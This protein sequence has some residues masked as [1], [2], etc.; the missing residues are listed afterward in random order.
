MT[1]RVMTRSATAKAQGRHL[2]GNRTAGGQANNGKRKKAERNRTVKQKSARSTTKSKPHAPKKT[3]SATRSSNKPTEAASLDTSTSPEG[4]GDADATH[5][6]DATME[7]EKSYKA[8]KKELK[9][10][11]RLRKDKNFR[12][13]AALLRNFIISAHR[14]LPGN[15]WLSFLHPV[16]I[17]YHVRV[18]QSTFQSIRENGPPSAEEKKGYPRMFTPPIQWNN[19]Q[20]PRDFLEIIT[21]PKYPHPE[22]RRKHESSRSKE[23]LFERLMSTELVGDLLMDLMHAAVQRCHECVESEPLQSG[24]APPLP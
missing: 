18:L 4:A 6:D 23:P 1:G 10:V 16:L 14:D 7:L 11:N 8:W 21:S 12:R 3:K 5:H 13:E 17:R 19:W 15:R 20:R 22:K 2:E 24:S 9:H